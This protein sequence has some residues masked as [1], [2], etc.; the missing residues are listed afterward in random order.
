SCETEDSLHRETLQRERQRE[1]RESA[2]RGERQRVRGK[3]VGR[4]RGER[5][6]EWT[7]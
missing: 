5:R 2:V 6:P 1:I 7:R 4:G 3:E